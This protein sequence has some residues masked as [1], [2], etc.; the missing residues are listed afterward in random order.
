VVQGE[1]PEFKPQYH[2]K[3]KKIFWGREHPAACILANPTRN[4]A[5]EGKVKATALQ[6]NVNVS[7]KEKNK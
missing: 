3:K 6:N 7:K 1:C 5:T 4:A 2:R